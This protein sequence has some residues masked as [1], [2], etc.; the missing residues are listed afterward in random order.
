MNLTKGELED[1][2]ESLEEVSRDN[3]IKYDTLEDTH[4]QDAMSVI[5]D[6]IDGVEK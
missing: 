1:A 3:R 2:Y 6:M 4:I 5:R